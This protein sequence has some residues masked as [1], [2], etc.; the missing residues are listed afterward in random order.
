MFYGSVFFFSLY[1]F[2][3]EINVAVNKRSEDKLTNKHRDVEQ[4]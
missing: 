4:Q 1:R 3:T 2:L